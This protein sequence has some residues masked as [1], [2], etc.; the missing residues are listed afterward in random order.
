MSVPRELGVALALGFGV[1]QAPLML[2]LMAWRAEPVG[3][4]VQAGWVNGTGS[5]GVGRV[6][7][8]PFFVV[9]SLAVALLSCVCVCVCVCVTYYLIFD[10]TFNI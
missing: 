6:S 8:G 5:V 4:V 10:K 1:S 2:G 3:E 9:S 7:L